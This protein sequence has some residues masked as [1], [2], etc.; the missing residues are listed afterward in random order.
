[1]EYYLEIALL[2][3]GDRETQAGIHPGGDAGALQV[4][5]ATGNFRNAS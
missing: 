5:Y 1:M 2:G 4:T 3:Q